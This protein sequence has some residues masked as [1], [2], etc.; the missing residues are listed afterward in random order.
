MLLTPAEGLTCMGLIF[1]LYVSNCSDKI[2]SFC[3]SSDFDGPN[4]FVEYPT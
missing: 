2:A 4:I 1:Q 3:F